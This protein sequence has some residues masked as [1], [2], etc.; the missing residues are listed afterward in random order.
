MPPNKLSS[1]KASFVSRHLPNCDE[2]SSSNLATPKR[3]TPPLVLQLRA[4]LA[5][6]QHFASDTRNG[7]SLCSTPSPEPNELP[8][9]VSRRQPSIIPNAT[10]MNRITKLNLSRHSA[11][12]SI[13]HNEDGPS[14]RPSASMLKDSD[15]IDCQ[16]GLDETDDFGPP[17]FRASESMLASD[18]EDSS[19]EPSYF[20]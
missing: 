3:I 12:P 5:I 9:A 6:S 2:T 7:D 16:N 13:E 19:V 4:H 11:V 8:F 20:C 1:C 15:E 14:L 17:S 10:L 18:G